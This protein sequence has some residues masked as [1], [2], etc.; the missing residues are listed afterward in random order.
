MGLD[1][2]DGEDIAFTDLDQNGGDDRW[3]GG[4]DQTE[5][6]SMLGVG[7]VSQ[8]WYKKKNIC[9]LSSLIKCKVDRESLW[10]LDS[11]W[12]RGKRLHLMC[13]PA[14]VCVSVCVVSTRAWLHTKVTISTSHLL[15]KTDCSCF[16]PVLPSQNVIIGFTCSS[17]ALCSEEPHFVLHS[18]FTPRLH[19]CFC[20]SA[21][22]ES[23]FNVTTA[24]IEKIRLIICLIPLSTCLLY[25]VIITNMTLLNSTLPCCA[26]APEPPVYPVE[27]VEVYVVRNTK[28]RAMLWSVDR[29]SVV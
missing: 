24:C 8:I 13:L 12:G 28:R 11:S 21:P 25:A 4:L 10:M 19:C 5:Q 27:F 1:V 22:L 26:L 2:S 16:G 6:T 20:H 17:H 14:C 23:L 7:Y 18:P 3:G 29:K 15:L 9:L